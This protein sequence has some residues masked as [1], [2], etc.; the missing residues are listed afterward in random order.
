M[1]PTDITDTILEFLPLIAFQKGT[2][3][4]VLTNEEIQD[5]QFLPRNIH[6]LQLG[7]FITESIP[8]LPEHV[9]TLIL[10]RN[11]TCSVSHLTMLE[12]IVMSPNLSTNLPPNLDE[13]VLSNIKC[14][15]H[16]MVNLVHL[17]SQNSQ[18]NCII[19]RKYFSKNA[20][21]DL[22]KVK[23][24]QSQLVYVY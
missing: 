1:M 11:Y 16:L 3:Y 20:R 18:V 7:P 21:R 8:L 5:L 4:V 9:T 10:P 19:I 17:A 12:K 14:Y 24:K 23:P 2:K 22:E 13:L 15:A 6:T